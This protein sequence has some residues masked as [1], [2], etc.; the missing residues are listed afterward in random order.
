[1]SSP[2]DRAQPVSLADEPDS[3]DNLVDDLPWLS[4][5]QADEPASST[6]KELQEFA[7][8]KLSTE[9]RLVLMLRYCEEL[10][11]AEISAV[12]KQPAS[13]VARI[14]DQVVS[15][16]RKWLEARER[17]EALVT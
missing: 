15:R 14:H 17:K 5:E 6:R 2:D 13:D 8:N 16:V 11:M 10:S 9:E 1:M 12:L 7:K 4:Q 3:T